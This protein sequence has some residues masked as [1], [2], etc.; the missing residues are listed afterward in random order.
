MTLGQTA[1]PQARAEAGHGRLP[2][3]AGGSDVQK[4]ADRTVNDELQDRNLELH[5]LNNDLANLLGGVEMA[6][7]MLGP[8]LRVRRFTPM[9]E[10]LFNLIPGDVGRPIGD[11]KLKLDLPDLEPLL[12]EVIDSASPRER[13]VRDRQGRWYSLRIRPYKTLENEIDGAVVLLVDVDTLRRA[14][15]YAESIVATVREPLLVLDADLR[16]QSASR[17]FYETF[18]VTPGETE[19][20]LL[21]DLADGQWNLP[22]LRRLLDEILPRDNSFEDFELER[23]F[24]R[25]GR[26]TLLLNARR[27]VQE[28]AARPLILLA[29]EDI[30]ARKALLQRV[31]ELA[32]ADRSKNEFL[33]LLAH[34]LRNPLAPLRNA[35]HL[36]E[37]PGADRA[38]VERA[39]AIMSRQ[40]QNMA[41]MIDDLLDVS[42][43]TQ[44]KIR[45]RKQPVELTALLTAAVE[46]AR[47]QL[48][49]RGQEL[50][51]S[52][53]TRPVELDADSTR[54]EQVF[55]N[56]LNNASKFTPK[57]GH[58]Q[59]TAELANGG[60][61]GEVVVRVRD[62]GDGMAPETLPRIFEPFM[63]ADRS[64]DRARGGLGIGL[65][66]VRSLVEL[67]GG[68]VEAR[69][70]GLEEG[71]E[72]VVRLPVPRR[73]DA[74]S[75]RHGAARD[76]SAA[77]RRPRLRPPQRAAS[78]WWTT[79]WIRP[80]AWPISCASR[81]TKWK[82]LTMDRRRW[83]GPPRSSPRSCSW[84]SACPGWTATRSPASC[85]GG[86]GPP[87]PCSWR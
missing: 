47:P 12:V 50:S 53:P 67:H 21:Y 41:R 7:V 8:D 25:I 66:L 10:K 18:Q 71:S 16:V 77:V 38:A 87:E 52:L 45:L 85:A 29:I 86:G 55:G 79:T 30:T 9:A 34:E 40:V 57:G 28:G 35:V 27:I 69:S 56:L 36:L 4:E 6:I 43:V 74:E 39:R 15:E 42:R 14:R 80:K 17:S 72:L 31:Q 26:R 75:E 11:I 5:Q 64:L 83:T 44:G 59:V 20:C 19:G 62:D 51:L 32:A 76:G 65:T 37:N 46:L 22:E 68:S 82:S 60:P 33:A 63:Q 13:E 54:L 78:W 61:R 48:E 58:I 73:R 23:D 3:A 84:T 24:E 2:Q 81:D 70:A 49:A 1:S